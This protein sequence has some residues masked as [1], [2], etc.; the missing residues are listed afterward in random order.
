M[1]E[2]VVEQNRGSAL[3][4]IS[5]RHRN[6]RLSV[7]LLVLKLPLVLVKHTILED[8]VVGWVFSGLQVT[9]QEVGSIFGV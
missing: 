7:I 5:I 2:G 4:N 9:G 3:I 1:Y 6:L 8:V